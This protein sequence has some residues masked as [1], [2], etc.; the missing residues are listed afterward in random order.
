[1]QVAGNGNAVHNVLWNA[2]AVCTQIRH[3]GRGATGHGS[4]QDAAHSGGSALDVM[5]VTGRSGRRPVSLR[6]SGAGFV[7]A[8]I[9]AGSAAETAAVARGFPWYVRR[10]SF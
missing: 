7:P 9:A 4:D 8:A 2:C 3:F 1:M 6:E 5:G 10:A